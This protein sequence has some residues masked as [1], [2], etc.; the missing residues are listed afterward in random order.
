ML[1][2]TFAAGVPELMVARVV[3]GL[4]TGAAAGAVG[5]GMLD[6]D[7]AKGT[8]TNAVAPLMGTATGGIAAGLLVQYLP[9][10]EHLVYLVLLGIF[11]V[12]AIGV[13]LMPETSTPKAGALGSL[14]PRFSA[15][16][17]ARRPLLVAAPV[18]VAVW[19][20]A[21]FYGSIGPTLV[22]QIVGSNSVVL[23]GAA[24]SVLAA[25]GAAAVLLLR[26]AAPR[27][28]MLFGVTALIT[29]VGITLLAIMFTSTAVFFIGTVIAGA[30]FGGG[31]QGAIRTV[32]PL[33]A[34]HERSGLLS[35]IYVVSY[36]AMGL[37][38]IIAG[39]LVVHTGGVMTT[40]REYGLA[41]MVL[42]AL[43]L[44]GVLR[45]RRQPAPAAT[46]KIDT[47]FA[48]ELVGAGSAR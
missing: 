17:A 16:S 11:L 6:L 12:Q 14:R 21:G 30:G 2:F 19:A 33:A 41:V 10:P 13:A 43:A 3:Q 47:E 34:P 36:L 28:V 20:L 32:I 26:N 42:A 8:I 48:P 45:P 35:T 24:L 4:A 37:P 38:A 40:A 31:F 9:A 15:P 7:K 18:L 44:P 46:V 5:A 1:V 27:T 23:G 25:S 39:F 22:Q 29:G